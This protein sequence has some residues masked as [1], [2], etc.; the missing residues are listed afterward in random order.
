MRRP[1]RR[2][3]YYQAFILHDGTVQAAFPIR[4]PISRG[5][6]RDF[7]RA[8]DDGVCKEIAR[9]GKELSDWNY[10]DRFRFQDLIANRLNTRRAIREMIF[11]RMDAI[12]N[13]IREIRKILDK[14]Q[15]CLETQIHKPEDPNPIG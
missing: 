8:D 6:Y 13:E 7:F 5:N 4:K 10:E 9:S 15:M 11:P 3:L 1:R 12:E 2:A 14:I